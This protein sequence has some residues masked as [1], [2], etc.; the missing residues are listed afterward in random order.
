MKVSFHPEAEEEFKIAIAY[1]EGKRI[2]LGYDFAVEIYDAINRAQA[3]P[4]AWPV[5]DA[6]IRRSLVR[7]FPFGVLYLEGPQELF[8]VAIMNLHRDPEYW[9]RRTG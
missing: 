9:Q 3:F 2:G 7:R 1:Y 4:G 8:V 6:K 5:I